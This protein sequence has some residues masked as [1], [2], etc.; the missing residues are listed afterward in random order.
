MAWPP[1]GLGRGAAARPILVAFKRQLQSQHER[2]GHPDNHELKNVHQITADPDGRL[3]DRRDGPVLGAEDNH[4]Q[5]LEDDGQ[6]DRDQQRGH[7]PGRPERAE[8]HL[9]DQDAQDP[10]GRHAEAEGH[11]PRQVIHAQGE[12]A[13]EGAD[14]VHLAVGEG[15][16]VHGA[17]DDHEPDGH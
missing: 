10:G 11:P 4:G 6:P 12:V 14:H 15:D 1:H 7:V 16:Q 17:E 3:I 5:V 13:D 2:P 8:G 9:L